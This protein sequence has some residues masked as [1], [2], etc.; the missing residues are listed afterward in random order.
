[1]CRNTEGNVPT[2]LSSQYTVST[3]RGRGRRRAAGG[4]PSGEKE[5]TEVRTHSEHDDNDTIDMCDCDLRE[6][7][8]GRA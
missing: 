1:M 6:P 2:V 8:T 7:A 5:V 4:R 3:C